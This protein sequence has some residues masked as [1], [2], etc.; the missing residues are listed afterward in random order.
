MLIFKGEFRDNLN[1]LWTINI[2][3]DGYSGETRELI[4]GDSP[5]VIEYVSDDPFKP[6]KYSG[7]SI[8]ILTPTILKEL[9]TGKI[10]DV[11]IEILKN[12]TLFW[13]GVNTPNVYNQEYWSQ[14]DET[15]VEAIDYIS[16]T[17]YYKWENQS[18]SNLSFL[19]ELK[20]CLDRVCDW[21]YKIYSTVDLTKFKN[22]TRNWEN[23]DGDNNKLSEIIESICLLGN[24]ACHY[25]TVTVFN[26]FTC[27]LFFKLLCLFVNRKQ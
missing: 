11:Q 15:T 21:D 2:Y 23:E 22:S 4:L 16:A 25:F 10:L 6:V 26:K 8:R 5:C 17:Q 18:I 19:D 1:N 7:A 20:M 14:L 9:Y 13:K 3:K 24:F 27:K 12:N